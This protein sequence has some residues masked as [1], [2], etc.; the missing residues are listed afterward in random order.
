MTGADDVDSTIILQRLLQ[1]LFAHGGFT[2]RKWNSSEP[3]VLQAISPELLESKEVHSISG[4]EQNYTKTLGL[5]WNTVT[6][7]FHIT[8]SKLPPSETVTKRILVSDIAKVFDVLEWFAPATVSVN[9]LLQRVWEER[10]DWD[11]PVPEA[12]QRIWHQWR[13]ELPSLACKSVPHCYFP[14]N[15]RIVSLQIHGFSDASE[16]AYAGVI[17]LRMVDSAGAVHT[18]LVMSKTEVSPI[19]RLSIPRLE[20][21]G[22]YVLARLLHHVKEI[23]QVSLSKV[24]AWTN[25][26]IALNWLT[27][28]PQRF[29]T[30]VGNC[31]S[32]IVD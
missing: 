1:D 19:K 21:C 10:V 8:I 6:D 30:Y 7:I 13:S 31:V 11:D 24:C 2:L 17:Y 4:L 18:S 27:G 5:E 22:A 20:L 26:A 14:K 29:K 15:V 12:I 23:F 16:D 25:S 3:L 9:I 28:N 32:E